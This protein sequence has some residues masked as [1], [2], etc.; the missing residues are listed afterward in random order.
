MMSLMVSFLLS[1]FPRDVLDEIRDLI[2]SV[3]EGSWISQK[4]P[5]N[6]LLLRQPWQQ[7]IQV[8][9]GIVSYNDTT[10]KVFYWSVF[11]QWNVFSVL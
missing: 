8:S 4:A 11:V 5:L 1:F 2:D 3:S 10:S 6:K 9:F 7:H